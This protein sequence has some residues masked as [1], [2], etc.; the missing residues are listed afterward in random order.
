[1]VIVVLKTCS[2]QKINENKKKDKELR[3][4]INLNPS[5]SAPYDHSARPSQTDRQTDMQ[6]EVRTSWQ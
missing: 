3:T 5:E 2:E 1:M 4:P 6:M